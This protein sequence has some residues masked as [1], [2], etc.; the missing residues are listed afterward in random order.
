MEKYAA[1]IVDVGDKL[2]RDGRVLSADGV[3]DGP[4]AETKEVI[5]GYMIVSGESY[6]DAVEVVRACP[7][8]QMPGAIME[9]RALSGARM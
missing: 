8:T 3:V 6:E 1:K 5:G 4:F 9:I 7:A 2:A